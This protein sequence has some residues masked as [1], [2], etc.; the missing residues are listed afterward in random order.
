M[1]FGWCA[2]AVAVISG[3]DFNAGM[4]RTAVTGVSVRVVCIM[5]RRRCGDLYRLF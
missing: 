2:K 1:L 5:L 3:S 4:L